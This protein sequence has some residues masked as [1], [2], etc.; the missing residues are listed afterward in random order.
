M[1]STTHGRPL[2]VA[3]KARMTAWRQAHFTAQPG[4]VPFSFLLDGR[5]ASQAMV[6]WVVVDSGEDHEPGRTRRT[7][8]W[9]DPATGLQVRCV[10][11][12]YEDYPTVEWTVFLRHDGAAD[13]P[14]IEDL[15][16]V[17]ARLDVAPIDGGVRL[18]HGRGG[19]AEASAYQPLV[20]QLQPGDAPGFAAAGGRPTNQ[21]LPYF[22]LEGDG[23]GIVAVIGWPGQWSAQWQC[24]EAGAVHFR[25]GQEHTR[26]RLHPGEEVRTPLVVLQFWHGGDRIEAQNVW[27]RWMKAYGMPKPGNQLPAPRVFGSSYRV[28]AEMTRATEANQKAFLDRYRE[29]GMSLDYWWMDAGWYPCG[30]SWGQVGTWEVDRERFPNG[31]RAVSDYAHAQGIG[32]MLWFE[33]ERV[34]AGSWLATEHP[35]WVIGGAEG[36][37]LNLG[38]PAA[39]EWLTDHVDRLLTREGIDIYRQD[40]NMDPLE[41]WRRHDSPDRQGLTE[42]HHVTGYLL[43]W[44]ELRRRHPDMLLDTCASGGRRNDL[45]TL[46][47]AVPLWRTDYQYEPAGMQCQTYGISFWM[48]FHGGGN[49]ADSKAAYGEPG[50]TAVEPY[51]FWSTCYPSINCGIDMTVP[52]VDYAALKELYAQRRQMIQLLYGDYYP[53][54]P[55]SLEQDAWM[56]WQFDDPQSGIGLVQ[57]FRRAASTQAEYR[58]PLRGLDPDVRYA[59]RTIDG[60]PLGHAHGHQLAQPG[61]LVRL[62]EQPG[63]AVI[64]YQVEAQA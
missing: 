26:F 13:S 20:T 58:L 16:A 18:H 6:S 40:F 42:N 2:A 24:A 12:E 38:L 30:G 45:E 34:S 27:R 52:E 7:L 60:K 19:Y 39:R 25:A 23:E 49:L 4:Q 9:R 31:L 56:A 57:A 59:L 3:A 62:D 10:V 1:N 28:Y 14:V 61:L 5:P 41:Y 64:L 22:A 47:R 36:G 50:Y 37:L 44:D 29:E 43:Y 32:T 54:T 46:R 48:P 33:P 53:L 35:E 55:Y 63:A 15:Q 17:D 11:V 21:E 8:T 51:A